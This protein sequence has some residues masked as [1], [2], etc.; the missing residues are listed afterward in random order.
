[1]P[2]FCE[3]TTLKKTKTLRQLNHLI[4]TASLDSLFGLRVAFW[5]SNVWNVIEMPT[6]M[7]IPFKLIHGIPYFLKKMNEISMASLAATGYTKGDLKKQWK[8]SWQSEYRIHS[9]S[10]NLSIFLAQA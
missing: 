10:T 1:M 4:P 6:L 2:L 5:I 8:V 9:A 7:S 3:L